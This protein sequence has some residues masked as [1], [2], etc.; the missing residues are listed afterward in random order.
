MPAQ[1]TRGDAAGQDELVVLDRI[2]DQGLSPQGWRSGA[3]ETYGW[4][5]H[6]YRKILFC[7]T[8]SIVFHT[9][10]GDL[11]LEAG[12]R[13]DLPAHTQHAATVGPQGCR[14][15]EAAAEPR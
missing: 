6:G 13:L 3:G 1:I 5:E 9:E 4:H 11:C 8:G 15:V 7:I 12:D 10:A 14:C 2:R